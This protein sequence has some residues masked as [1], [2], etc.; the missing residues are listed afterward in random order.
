MKTENLIILFA[1]FIGLG[2]VLHFNTKEGQP[3]PALQTKKQMLAKEQNKENLIKKIEILEKENRTLRQQLRQITME[4]EANKT[5]A[6][7]AIQDN[8]QTPT[9]E[10]AP[11]GNFGVYQPYI[12]YIKALIEYAKTHT[13]PTTNYQDLSDIFKPHQ[14]YGI[15][16]MSNMNI[17]IISNNFYIKLLQNMVAIYSNKDYYHLDFSLD[18]SAT[19]VGKNQEG[20]K[21]CST[22][23][24][25]K[26]GPANKRIPSW[27]SYALPQKLFD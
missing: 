11:Q 26:E 4:R 22:Q 1:F 17:I 15:N 7:D 25:G 3:D 19:C 2:I 8:L 12:P 5:F 13:I 16:T 21:A 23:L 20:Y 27:R 18:G 6:Q 9:Q 24:G 14:P 10:A